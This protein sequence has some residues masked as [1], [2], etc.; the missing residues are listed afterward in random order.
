MKTASHIIFFSILFLFSS[1][2]YA[3][4]DFI[5]GAGATPPDRDGRVNFMYP[6]NNNLVFYRPKSLGPTGVQLYWEGQDT[7][8]NGVLYCTAHKSASGGPMTIRNA[9]VDSGLSYG[10]HKLFKTSVTGLYYTLKISAIWSA[11][12]TRADVSEIYIGDTEA[13]KFHFVFH[14]ADM[15]RRCKDMDNNHPQ[16]WG[17]GGIFQT[18]TVEFYTD[19]T[20]A[21]TATQNITLLSTSDYIYRFKA[22]DAGSAIQ[23]YSGP[24]YINFNLSNVKL[25]LPTCFSSVVTGDTVQNSTVALGSYEV[26]QIKNG[27]TPV[28]FQITLQNCIRVQNIETKM[29]SA[30]IGQQNKKLLANTLQGNGAAEGVGVLIEG[31]KNSVNGKMVLEPNVGTS[32]YKAYE[33]EIDSSGGIY[34]GKGQGTTQ[35]LEFQATLKQDGNSTI[36]AGDF[37]ATGRFQITYP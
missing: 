14:D 7:A 21:P 6:G 11:Y 24:I 29:T 26:S 33:S 9:M 22:E 35:P 12:N 23:G 15:E 10:G 36:K 19:A 13:Q 37:E 4:I 28:P 17:L 18:F 30:K 20:F 31:L 2:C 5:V 16:F 25:S 3:K 34:P 32:V 1:V 27:A 8:S